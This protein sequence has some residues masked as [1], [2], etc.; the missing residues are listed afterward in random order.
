MGEE[1]KKW[2]SPTIGGNTKCKGY[3]FTIAVEGPVLLIGLAPR[4]RLRDRL[5]AA[6]WINA[7]T[8]PIVVLVWPYVVWVPLGHVAYLAVAETFAPVAECALF[9]FAFGSAQ[10]RCCRSMYRD[11]AAIIAANL[12]SFLL[13]GWCFPTV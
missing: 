9:W 2:R 8:Y 13:G 6:L 3:V 5:L 7:C 4:H 1:G 10:E 11:F 12:A